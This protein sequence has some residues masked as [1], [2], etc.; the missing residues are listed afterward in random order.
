M[1]NVFV[2]ARCYQDANFARRGIGR[3]TIA[4][5]RSCPGAMRAGMRLIALC[6]PQLPQLDSDF[7][8]VFDQQRSE[9]RTPIS[10]AMFFNPSPLTHRSAFAA[11]LLSGP[12][13]LAAA[14][15][16]D[17][18]PYDFPEELGDGAA[19]VEYRRALQELKRY[20]V[21]FTNSFYTRDRVAAILNVSGSRIERC[22]IAPRPAF[23][24]PD[25]GRLA[26]GEAALLRKL[27]RAGGQI[28]ASVAGDASRKNTECAATAVRLLSERLGARYRLA[29]VGRYSRERRERI[30]ELHPGGVE[31]L[32]DISDEALAILLRRAI[33]C[34]VP[35]RV[36]GFSMPVV[37]TVAAGGLVLASDCPAHREFIESP[38]AL[39]AA[40]NPEQL[41]DRMAAILE[42][43]FRARLIAEQRPRIDGLSE[44][45]VA[46]RFWS[47]I[48]AEFAAIPLAP[49]A[50]A[51]P[52][53][54]GAA[55]PVF[56]L[57]SPYVPQ[58]SG[59]ALG[60]AR[61][62][63]ALSQSAIVDLF[64]HSQVPGEQHSYLR[65]IR[66]LE[67]ARNLRG[68][69]AVVYVL[70]NSHA[71]HGE[72]YR[73]S[74]MERCGNYCLLGD[75]VLVDLQFAQRGPEGAADYAA[76]ILGR[77]VTV[78]EYRSWLARPMTLPIL[79]QE[80]FF[81]DGWRPIVY[82]RP[83]QA[84][85][86][87]RAGAAPHWVPHPV[88]A[89]F[90]A[91][92]FAPRHRS[93]LRDELG[94]ADRDINIVTAG[95]VTEVKAAIEAVVALRDL[96][97][98][99]LSPRLTFAGTCRAPL[100]TQ[101]EGLAE[102][103]GVAG[104]VFFT[105]QIGRARYQDHIIAADV[106]LQLRKVPFGQTSGGLVDCIVGGLVTVAN[107]AMAAAVDAP[108]YVL[109]V[110]DLFS[111]LLVAE[112]IVDAYEAARRGWRPASDERLHYVDLHS[113]QKMAEGFVELVDW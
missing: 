40:D 101:L 29:V 20:D 72:I 6:D 49:A 65:W 73:L 107:E 27:L 33:A 51:K 46:Q 90:E 93:A 64:T 42:P 17:L 35:S 105:G 39:F 66:P 37:E 69:D 109:T 81:S 2:D 26:A 52:A 76:Q 96:L 87:R 50:T 103:F 11:P 106:G 45:A 60:A 32:P 3:S 14:Y 38:G 59:I 83:L 16:H 99:G 7:A 56:A 1:I 88:T 61:L 57:I 77:E 30:G 84:E 41:A 54:A 48:V 67:A 91:E 102:K 78:A 94:F 44:A 79:G 68:Y 85:I 71:Y 58:P 95:V 74:Q 5:L 113:P 12:G 21:F 53:I 47:R 22:G 98:W 24:D 70:G 55:R 31:F 4:L 62:L 13:T 89:R 112:K 108:S 92:C 28:F 9:T 19:Y 111:P 34:L 25:E 63:K 110:P 86:E 80:E 104:R 43:D 18:I 100:Q 97:D 75:A 15:V 23:F 10:R 8:E 82:S 36:E